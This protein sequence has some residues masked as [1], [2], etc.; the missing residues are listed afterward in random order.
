MGISTKINM[1]IWIILGGVI[2]LGFFT[3]VYIYGMPDDFVPPK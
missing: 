2:L 3:F 1:V